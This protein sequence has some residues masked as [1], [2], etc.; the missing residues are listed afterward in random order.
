M[1]QAIDDEVVSTFAVV[2]A[3]EEIAPQLQRRYRDLMTRAAL[4]TPHDI[5]PAVASRIAAEL[6]AL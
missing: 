5:D 1:G 2:G 4:Y 6:S 3:P